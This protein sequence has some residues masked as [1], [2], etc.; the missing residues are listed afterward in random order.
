M[1]DLIINE[2]N[3][4]INEINESNSKVRAILIDEENRVLIANYG[5]VILFPGGSIDN[6]ENINQAII[7]ELYEETGAIYEEADLT[8]LIQLDFFQRNYVKRNGMKKIV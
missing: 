7:R 5:G 6:G 2:G 8:F 3:L 4:E 1:I